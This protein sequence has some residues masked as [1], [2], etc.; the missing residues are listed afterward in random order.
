[1]ITTIAQVVGVL[2]AGVGGVAGSVALFKIGPERRKITAEAYRAGVDSAAVLSKSA[3]DF[4]APYEAQIKF[5]NDQ[6]AAA[7]VEI[8][9]LRSEVAE[10]RAGLTA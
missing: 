6:L 5:L 9:S 8:T 10:L 3:I 4:M 7:R 2:V 1:V